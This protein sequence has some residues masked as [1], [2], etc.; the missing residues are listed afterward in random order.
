M[1]DICIIGGGPA[2]MSAA[3]TAVRLN[4][5]LRVCIIEKNPMVGKKIYA[6]GNGRCNLSNLTCPES[7]EVWNFFNQVGIFTRS[8]ESGRMY[9]ASEQAA[10]VVQTLENELV[11]LHIEVK[12]NATPMSI[13]KVDNGFEIKLQTETFS[14]KRLL[15][16]TGGKAGPQYGCLG[17]G[18]AFARQLGHHISRTY[19]VLAPLE[20]QGTFPPLKGIRAKG[21]V[22][23]LKTGTKIAEEAGEIQFTE[24]GLS[25][26]CVFNLSRFIRL[27]TNLSLAD[28]MKE[29]TVSIDFIPTLDENQIFD[30][31]Q[32]HSANQD[33]KVDDLLLTMVHPG[34]ARDIINRA[35]AKPERAAA[36]L[37]RKELLQ[38][39]GLLKNWQSTVT[40]VKGW[41]KA[42]CT[43]GGVV[44]TEINQDTYESMI[45]PGLYFAGE[46][47]DYDGP[48]GGFNLH[49]AWDSGIKAG[50]AMA[51][52]II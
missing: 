6:T 3:I 5:A 30:Y 19:P 33:L 16:S 28:A 34:I 45:T 20:C 15:L 22:N 14:C 35:G 10:D 37:S 21:T 27:N 52:E 8:E 38:I 31:L 1:Y 9:P 36:G 11:A 2:G 42:Q 12:T 29:Y 50:K 44:L 25:G 40:G 18:Y 39:A 32:T 23:L 43:G 7:T 13:N 17:E 41:K 46:L 24:D 51:N 48:S 26:I 49:F 47:L 4:P